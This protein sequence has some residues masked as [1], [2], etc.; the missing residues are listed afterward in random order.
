MAAVISNDYFINSIEL[1]NTATSKAE[2]QDIAAMVTKYEKQYLEAILGYETAKDFLAAIAGV[3]TSGIWF[4]LWKGSEFTA[5]DGTLQKW[6]GFANSE[7]VSPIANYCYWH[8][9][10]KRVSHTAGI[11]EVKNQPENATHIS[12]VAKASE[13]WNEMVEMNNILNDFIIQNQSDYPDYLGITHSNYEL[14][15]YVNSMNI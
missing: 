13:A 11:G 6:K 15:N 5:A 1:P 12:V 7:Y 4:D 14:F 2:G 9:M 8:I 3:P 10:R